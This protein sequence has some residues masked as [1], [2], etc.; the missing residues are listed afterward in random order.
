[1]DELN[2]ENGVFRHG[3]PKV[4][5]K[6]KKKFFSNFLR[7]VM[8]EFL[9]KFNNFVKKKFNVEKLFLPPNVST[10]ITFFT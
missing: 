7:I 6:N 9:N 10:H 4:T 5:H 3:K 2:I 1:M 8:V